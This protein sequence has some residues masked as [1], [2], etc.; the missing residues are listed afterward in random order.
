MNDKEDLIYINKFS[1]ITIAEACRHFGYNH[2]N[3][4]MGKCG[5]DAERNVRK[6]LENKISKI[7][8]EE[9]EVYVEKNNSLFN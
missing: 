8:S 5:R 3:L 4:R 6:Y 9:S 7:Y 2:S 1:K